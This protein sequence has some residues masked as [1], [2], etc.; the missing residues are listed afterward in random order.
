VDLGIAGRSAIVCGSSRGL[1]RSCAE[2]LAAEGVDVVLNGRD[3]DALESAVAELSAR[4]DVRVSGVA[5]DV[6]DPATRA[7]LLERCPEADILVTNNA[8]PAP[9]PFTTWDRDDWMGALEANMVAPLMLI[10][11]LVDGMA[12][13]G[14]GRIINVTSAMVT[15]P[16]PS[17]G[18][19]SGARAG[20]TAAVKGL[21][22]A[23]ASDNVTINNLLP[24]RFDTDRQVF[25]ARKVVVD[26]GI[27][28]EEARAR[29]L[30]SVAAGRL[31]RPEEF[32]AACAF[33]CS[34][35]AGFISG[36][37]L[38]LDGGSY[39]GLV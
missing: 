13:R 24:E 34:A 31:G 23:V 7:A 3:P 18:L 26:Q 9:A 25:M 8:G 5:G 16:H 33:L 4:H 21:S 36:N 11:G 22:R 1:G 28:Y 19:S 10:R 6:G 20:L 39:V 14:F 2:A 17:M 30:T 32:G 29:Q 15:S 12:S 35:H 37:N 38:H 27:S